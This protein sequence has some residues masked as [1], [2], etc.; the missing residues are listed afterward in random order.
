M[1]RARSDDGRLKAYKLRAAAHFQIFAAQCAL[2]VVGQHG[3]TAPLRAWRA[4]VVSC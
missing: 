1:R 3:F 2:I 4:R